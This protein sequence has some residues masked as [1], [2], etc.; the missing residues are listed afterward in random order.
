VYIAAEGA[1]SARH[2]DYS[3]SQ[4][5]TYDFGFQS[6]Q[7]G[8]RGSPLSGRVQP[9][10]ELLAGV[11]RHGI[12]ER[13]LDKIGAWGSPEFSLQPGFGID[14][15]IAQRL[16]LRLGSDLRLLFRHDNRFDK[17]YRAQQYRFNLGLAAHLGGNSIQ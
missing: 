7:A 9:Y 16:A 12:W 3:S 10:A 2:E 17:N 4:G 5:G 13:R 6:I 1:F 15:L 8:P 14:V 11:T